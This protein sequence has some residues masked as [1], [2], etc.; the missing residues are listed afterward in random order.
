MACASCNSVNIT[1]RHG[2]LRC[3]DCG[4]VWRDGVTPIPK[5]ACNPPVR[6]P[7]SELD[8]CPFC[9]Y[10]ADM[11]EMPEGWFGV[12]LDGNCGAMGPVRPTRVEAVTAYNSRWAPPF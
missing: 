9:G 6:Y 2:W 7:P 8:T 1:A 3:S 10:V 11:A 4:K 12:C 5:P